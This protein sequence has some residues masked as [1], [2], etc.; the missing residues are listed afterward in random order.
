MNEKIEYKVTRTDYKKE[1]IYI[2]AYSEEEAQ[3]IAEKTDSI[4][5][6]DITNDYSEEFEVEEA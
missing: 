6:S 4:E 3:I 1:E 5:W 2:E